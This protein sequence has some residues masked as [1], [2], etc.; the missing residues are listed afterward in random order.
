MTP[1]SKE[2]KKSNHQLNIPSFPGEGIH[3]M[4][5]LK[6]WAGGI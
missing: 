2:W 5:F 1:S 3:L 4:Q 6:L